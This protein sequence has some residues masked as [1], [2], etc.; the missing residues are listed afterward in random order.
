MHLLAQFYPRARCDEATHPL[1]QL[2]MRRFM[3]LLFASGSLMLL[4][5]HDLVSMSKHEQGRCICGRLHQHQQRAGCVAATTSP[6]LCLPCST[7]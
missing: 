6:H 1:Q 5:V 3:S 4:R 7:A 2:L